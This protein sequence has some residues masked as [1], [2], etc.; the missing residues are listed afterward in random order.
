MRLIEPVGYLDSIGLAEAAACVLTDSGGLQEET[1]FLRVPCLTLRPN[2]ERP[3]TITMGSNRL[4]TIATLRTDLEEA[5]RRR[6]SEESA[7]LPAALGRP[8]G[9][10][11]RGC[12]RR[13]PLTCLAHQGTGAGSRRA[14]PRGPARPRRPRRR[15]TRSPPRSRCRSEQKAA[16]VVSVGRPLGGLRRR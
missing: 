10:A 1:T 9:G 3:V 7:S 8:G 14:G 11:H 12:A 15:E 16:G 4:T 5:I 2:T 6:E 13:R